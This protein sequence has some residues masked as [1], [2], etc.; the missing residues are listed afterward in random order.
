M[1]GVKIDFFCLFFRS[2]LIGLFNCL[3]ELFNFLNVRILDIHLCT[4][5]LISILALSKL[6]EISDVR[7][8]NLNSIE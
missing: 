6:R 5:Q 3:F 2:F 1:L 8:T 7:Y 4:E